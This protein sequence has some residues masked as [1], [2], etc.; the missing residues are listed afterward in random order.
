MDVDAENNV[1]KTM[2]SLIKLGMVSFVLAACSGEKSTTTTG[3]S[4]GPAV[5]EAPLA[6]AGTG[7]IGTTDQP[8]VLDGSGSSDPDGDEIT[9]N[10]AFSRVP[11]SSVFSTSAAM[12][13]DSAGSSS[14]FGAEAFSVNNISDPVSSF[15]PDV[16]GIYIVTL[17]VTD[18][19]GLSSIEDAVVYNIEGGQ[20]PVANAG[21]DI[22]LSEGGTAQLDGSASFDPMGRSLS[23]NWRVASG[24]AA[25]TITTPDN[26]T[27]STPSLTP[28]APGLYVVSLMVNNGVGNSNPDAVS[29]RVSSNDPQ[30][31]V[32]YAGED[33]TAEDCSSIPLDA[34][35]SYDPNNDA[36]TYSWA[37]QSKPMDSTANLNSFSDT[38]SANPTFYADVAGEY[39]LSVAVNDGDRWSSP[40]LLTLVLT[41]RVANSAPQVNAGNG[42]NLDAGTAVCTLSGY[43]YECD[44]CADL[45]VTLGV[46]GSVVDADGDTVTYS[47]NVVSGDA[48]LS[49][50]QSIT[51]DAILTGA[52]PSEP[53]VC[54]TTTF[55]FELVAEDCPGAQAIDSVQVNV[56]C[57]GV[58]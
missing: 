37:L 25:S 12:I 39:G 9:F 42:F 3:S 36:L 43:S 50:P 53:N 40:D 45:N 23:Y 24:P 10:W 31:P 48:T 1:E 32:A 5:G 26:P 35:G 18:S 16:E 38:S 51:T 4:S 20:L 11:E 47:W 33:I 7:G 29:V 34:T 14:R 28:D 2:H 6:V 52:A 41:D 49:D 27:S 46:N 54:E 15:L 21:A 57:C 58:E 19:T 22:A 13:D 8:V 30:P 17:V 56:N 44:A 55:D